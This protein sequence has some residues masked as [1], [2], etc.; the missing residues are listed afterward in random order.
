[1][2]ISLRSGGRDSNQ[3]IRSW[4]CD[5]VNSSWVILVIGDVL[6]SRLH[7]VLIP[8]GYIVLYYFSV[9]NEFR[10]LKTMMWESW[11]ERFVEMSLVRC[12]GTIG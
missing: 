5:V 1:M 10:F 6:L 9:Y 7:I 3:Q 11:S 12:L 4:I 8:Q 2:K